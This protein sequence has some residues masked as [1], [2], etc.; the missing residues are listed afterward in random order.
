M[1]EKSQTRKKFYHLTPAERRQRLMDEGYLSD[2]DAAILSG[3]LGLTSDGADHMIE[4]VIGTFN[5]PLGIA[6]HFRI[7]GREVPIPMVVEEPSIVAGASFMAKLALGTG[8]FFAQAQQPE[9]IGQIQILDVSDPAYARMKLLE[10]KESLLSEAA[11]VD[12]I[13]QKLGGGPKDM[14]ERLID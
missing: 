10:N 13:L 1:S 9:M 12:P 14:T 4:N 3:E 8:G 7:N 5:L 11:E 6:R 2:E